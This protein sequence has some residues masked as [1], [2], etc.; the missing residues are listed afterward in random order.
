MG[1]KYRFGVRVNRIFSR[2]SVVIDIN[3]NLFVPPRLA[4]KIVCVSENLLVSILREIEW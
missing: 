2:L 3:L 4:N 1:E